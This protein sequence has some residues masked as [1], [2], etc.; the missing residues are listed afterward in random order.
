MHVRQASQPPTDDTLTL[1]ALETDRYSLEGKLATLA[2]EGCGAG[3]TP[4]RARFRGR[5]TLSKHR[6]QTQDVETEHREN[7]KVG[8]L[9]NSAQK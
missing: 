2:G 8:A 4:S 6:I 9:R 5:G 7:K 1:T 3:D